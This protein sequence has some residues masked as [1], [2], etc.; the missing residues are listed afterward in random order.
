MRVYTCTD[1]CVF[2][3]DLCQRLG[4]SE[5]DTTITPVGHREVGYSI[6]FE[7]LAV[8]AL[9]THCRLLKLCCPFV[10]RGEL[11]G[12][13]GANYKN[14]AGVLDMQFETPSMLLTGGYDTI[15]RC[16]DLRAPLHRW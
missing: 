2:M 6:S 10:C 1:V 7:L 11:L 9:L 14:G 4:R 16:W 12:N 15:V 3:Q 5:A 13:L 8:W